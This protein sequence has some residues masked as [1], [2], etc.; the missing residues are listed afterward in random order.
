VLT[1]DFG[2]LGLGPGMRVL[3]LGSGNGRHAFEVLRRGGDVVAVDTDRAG[4]AEV[5][6]MFA[7]MRAAGEIPP[8]P[9]GAPAAGCLQADARR[10]PFPDGSFDRVIA[11]EVLEHVQDDDAAMAEIARVLRPGGSAAVTVP[12]FFPEAVCWALSRGYHDVPG[13]HVRIYRRTQLR[14]RLRRAGLAVRGGHH[15]HALHAPYWWLHCAL[16]GEAWPA[17]AYHRLLVWDIV[18]RPWPTRLAEAL[19]NPLLGKSLVVY[20]AKP[21]D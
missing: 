20:L 17:R 19:L 4:L 11:A 13:G 16:G 6:G 18:R 9:G 10:L 7:A 1:V 8:R 12:R 14:G 2:R 15:A 21:G 5:R 3:D